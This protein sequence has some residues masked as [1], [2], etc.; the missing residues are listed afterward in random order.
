MNDYRAVWL[1][2]WGTVALVHCGLACVL[3]GIPRTIALYVTVAGATAGIAACCRAPV[4][5]GHSSSLIVVVAL[6]QGC[7]VGLGAVGLIAL[8][9]VQ[10]ASAL[11]VLL[12]CGASSPWTVGRLRSVTITRGDP[13]ASLLANTRPWPD[14]EMSDL[15]L[16]RIWRL[17]FTWL[18][19]AS[20]PIEK[21][22]IVRARQECLAELESRHPDAVAAWLA[23]W[24]E[25]SAVLDRYITAEAFRDQPT[26]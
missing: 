19:A 15:E 14:R 11:L 22:A 21:A 8:A 13:R 18:G 4:W 23:S 24:P 2:A 6:R 20:G 16:C 5:A 1:G 9:E 26:P 25:S 10:G 7:A 3:W 12:L 17:S